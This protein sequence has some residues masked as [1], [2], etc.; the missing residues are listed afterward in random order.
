MDFAKYNDITKPL[1]LQPHMI[2]GEGVYAK[3]MHL[4]RMNDQF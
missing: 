4:I 2:D 3:F 1:V